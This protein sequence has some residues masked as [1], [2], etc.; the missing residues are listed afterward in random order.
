MERALNLQEVILR[1]LVKKILP[2]G[3]GGRNLGI[4][5]SRCDVEK[6]ATKSLGKTDCPTAGMGSLRLPQG[7]KSRRLASLA[8]LQREPLSLLRSAYVNSVPTFPAGH[9]RQ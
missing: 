2:S 4:A 1:A 5:T 3:E 9:G 7:F 8:R 6:S